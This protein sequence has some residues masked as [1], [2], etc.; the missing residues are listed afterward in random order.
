MEWPRSPDGGECPTDGQVFVGCENDG[1][2][3]LEVDHCKWTRYME[4]PRSP[5]ESGSPT[6]GLVV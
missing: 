3:D 2:G 1:C 6:D 4:Y 5:D